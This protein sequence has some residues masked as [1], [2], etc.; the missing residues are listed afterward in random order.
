MQLNF[1]WCILIVRSGT[2]KRLLLLSGK[3]KT[4]L[5]MLNVIVHSISYALMFV[6]GIEAL[7]GFSV[8][9]LAV[10]FNFWD[11]RYSHKMR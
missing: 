11:S 9:L 4:V 7:L 1:T 8:T 3:D 6:T 5:F 10:M 2:Y